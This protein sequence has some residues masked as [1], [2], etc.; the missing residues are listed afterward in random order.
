MKELRTMWPDLRLLDL[1]GIEYPIVLAPMA[2][3]VDADLVI[4][5]AQAGGLGSLPV[6]LFN[7]ATMRSQM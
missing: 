6:A 4:A 5:V 3:A 1:F 2:G 7:E